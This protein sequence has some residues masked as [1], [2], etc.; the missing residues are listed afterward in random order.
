MANSVKSFFE[1]KQDQPWVEWAIY[2]F[3]YEEMST[4][5][6]ASDVDLLLWKLYCGLDDTEL[7]KKLV[8]RFWINLS[9]ISEK[10]ER[11]DIGV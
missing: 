4:S 9:K 7:A 3:S 6:V 10:H 8:R 5:N 1:V 2:I 11:I